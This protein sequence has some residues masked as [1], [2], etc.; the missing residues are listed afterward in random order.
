MT[1]S[2][3]R[4]GQARREHPGVEVLGSADELWPR[5]GEF[6]LVVVAAPNSAH[7]PLAE[8][9]VVAGLPVVVDK[10]FAPTVESGERLAERA[11]AAGVP[12]AV[13]HNRRWDDDFLALRRLVNDGAIGDVIRVESRFDRWKPRLDG[14]HWRERAGSVEAGGLLFDLGSH[15]IDQ[16]LVLFGEPSSGWTE[17]DR[18]RPG[19]EVDDDTFVALGYGGDGPRVHLWMSVLQAEQAPRFRVAGLEGL[20]EIEGLDPQEDALRRGLRPGAAEWDSA[21]GGRVARIVDGSGEERFEPIGPGNYAAF[22]EGVREMVA[23]GGPPP[24]SADEA[25]AALRVIERARAAAGS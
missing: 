17:L 22:Y 12:L 20:I 21:L 10:P 15:L 2:A 23:S 14:D 5:A 4:A 16:A 25:L 6:D 1:G 24:V 7:V 11:R 9:A 8:A 19:A 3:E 18:R 13:F